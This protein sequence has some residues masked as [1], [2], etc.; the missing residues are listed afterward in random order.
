MPRRGRFRVEFDVTCSGCGRAYHYDSLNRKGHT[1]AK[2]NSCSVNNRRPMV[3]LRAV[4]L[5][6]GKCRFCGYK[7]CVNALEF[8]HLE[9]KKFE[10]GDKL[11]RAWAALVLELKKCVLV[12]SNCHAELHAGIIQMPE[13]PNGEGR[14]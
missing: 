10:I 7:R 8:H 13:S 14:A 4:A 12:C 9:D 6:G 1:K 3:K 5:L 11:N 2:C